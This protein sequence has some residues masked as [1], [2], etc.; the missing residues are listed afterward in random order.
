MGSKKKG[1]K[2]D[3]GNQKRR[4]KRIRAAWEL[5]MIAWEKVKACC[6]VGPRETRGWGERGGR[7]RRSK[8]SDTLREVCTEG[9]VALVVYWE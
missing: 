1:C 6:S 9:E 5:E 3:P 7:S 2:R 4:R 8:E